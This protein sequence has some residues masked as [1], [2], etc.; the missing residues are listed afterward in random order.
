MQ[1]IELL[2]RIRTASYRA[3]S[4]LEWAFLRLRG[5]PALPP[6][7]LRRHVGDPRK[8]RSAA[9]ET[10]AWIERLGLLESNPR[11]LDIG[12]GCGAMLLEFQERLGKSGSYVGFDVHA[13]SIRWAQKHWRDDPRIRFE[14]ARIKTPYSAAESGALSDYRF[15]VESS[16]ADFVLAKSVFTHMLV[17]EL[18]SYLSEIRRVLNVSGHA[19]ISFF[20]FAR[21]GGNLPAFQHCDPAEPRVRWRMAHH[22]HAAVAY[23]KEL[24]LD[25]LETS[26]LAVAHHVEGFWPG[27]VATPTGQDQLVV[28]C[29]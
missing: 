1:G 15:P 5:Q 29:K 27:T 14:T 25:L 16:W 8:F 19:L 22:P 3:A 9:I 28:K 24:V 17:D 2:R 20:L 26:G 18:Q 10:M 21:G 7:W 11:I 13:P 23:D 12:S 6:L 4:P